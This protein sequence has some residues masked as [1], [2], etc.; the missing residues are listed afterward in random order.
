MER[1]I[2]KLR[3]ENAELKEWLQRYEEASAEDREARRES[4][5][6]TI[7]LVRMIGEK[8]SNTN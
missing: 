6:A 5:R 7:E 8:R 3:Q 1:E 2:W 4:F